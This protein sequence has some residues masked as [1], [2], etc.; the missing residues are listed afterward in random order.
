MEKKKK[1][2]ILVWILLFIVFIA[3]GYFAKMNMP[4][5]G[6]KVV[7]DTKTLKSELVKINELAT[8]QKEYRETITKEKD[9]FY[10]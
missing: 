10:I 6:H 5:V 8:Y 4:S 7:I 1:G 3:A 2:G 9:G